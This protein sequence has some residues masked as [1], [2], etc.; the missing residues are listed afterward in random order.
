MTM[1]KQ[2]KKV[3]NAIPHSGGG[4]AAWKVIGVEDTYGISGGE[5]VRIKGL[6]V[7]NN[8]TNR[9]VSVN[10]DYDGGDNDGTI[11]V[12]LAQT[13]ALSVGTKLKFFG[14]G[15]GKG[16][17]DQ[18]KAN[19]KVIINSYPSSNRTIYLDLD[20]FITIGRAS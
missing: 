17:R 7:N 20:N 1:S 9:I 6:N 12:E 11:T 18:L 5:V 13:A 15:L 10:G 3:V 8:G 14:S 2:F 16:S 19:N 4:S